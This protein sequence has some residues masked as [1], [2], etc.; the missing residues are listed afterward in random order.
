MFQWPPYWSKKTRSWHGAKAFSQVRQWSIR[1]AA[2]FDVRALHEIERVVVEAEQNV[3]T[4]LLDPL[5]LFGVATARTL[6]AEPPARLVHSHLMAGAKF[7]CGGQ[8]ERCGY[9]AC[10]TAQHCNA[11]N[12]CFHPEAPVCRHD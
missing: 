5:M 12:S 1:V 3:K 8:F 2:Q 10:A 6:A 9:G 7:G 4:V 11:S